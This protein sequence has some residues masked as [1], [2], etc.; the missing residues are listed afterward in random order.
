MSS[1]KW[2]RREFLRMSALTTAGL[3]LAACAKQTAAPAEEPTQAPEKQPTPAPAKEAGK[4]VFWPEWGGK[5]AD[6]LQAQVTKFT[7]RTGI[8]VEFLPIRDH[9]RMIAS[10]GAGSP[11]DLLMTWDA[12][13]VG[14][15]GFNE[16]IVDLNPYIEA[17]GFDL[18]S[19]HPL[20]VVSGDLMGLKQIGLPL[21]NYLNTVLYWNKDAFQTAGLDPEAPPATWE[22]TRQMHDKITV[23]ENGQIVKWGY[24]VMQGQDGHPSVM[25]YGFGGEIY[26]PDRRT[27][28][29]GDPAKIESLKWLRSFYA[30]YGLDEVRRWQDSQTMGADSPTN[31]LYTAQSGMILTGEW[32]PSY[33]QRLEGMEVKYGATTMPYP[34]AKPDVEGTMAANSNPLVIPKDAKNPE[35]GWQFIMFISEPENS[36]EMCSIV[37]NASPVK[38]GVKLQAQKADNATY[39]WLLEEVWTKANIRPLTINCPVG[40]LYMDVIG[41]ETTLVL[42]D[43]KDPE[44]AMQVV[45]DEVQPELDAALA[46]LG[47]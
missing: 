12:G 31:P 40:A 19:L 28:T 30:D 29:P 24:Q 38:E 26:S 18:D 47:L 22:E 37:G 27:L 13:A 21:T 32:M 39:K 42:E 46:E 6:A 25:A 45:K 14:T 20:G 1:K 15:W 44:E 7:E 3:A 11:P 8:E 36:A 33:I 5:D 35:A 16:A 23:V 4:M 41:R 2:S 9:A 43:G 10:M 34:Q 17:S